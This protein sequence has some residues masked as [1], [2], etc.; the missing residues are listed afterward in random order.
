MMQKPTF[1]T[2]TS[3][4]I[5]K[6]TSTKRMMIDVLIALT[7]VAFFSIYRFGVDAIIRI[8][9]SLLIFILV[10]LIYFLLVTKVEGFNFKDRLTQ[11]FK[12]YSVNHVTAPAVSGLIFAMLLPDGLNL[13]VVVMGSI[14]GAFI[15][16]M[17]FGG[18]GYNLFNPAALGRV[19]I[20]VSFASFFV[21]S[22]G[23]VDAA[24]GA[25]PLSLSFAELFNYY[26]LT[27]L[28]TG[29]IPGSLGEVNSILILI[30]A[31]YLFIRKSAD[32]RPALSAL[33]IFVVL[34]AIA[35]YI[36]YPTMVLEYVLFHLLSGG[37]LFG[38]AFMVTDPA[39][40]P[41]TRPGRWIYGLIIGF[42][43]FAIRVWG[44]LPEGVAFAIL[45]GNL[46]VPLIDY[47]K[48]AT[49]QYRLRFLIGYGVSFVLLAVFTYL[50]LGGIII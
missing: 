21:G 31:L 7:P 22:Y 46:V 30:G 25:T 42:L 17:V 40:S 27:D 45:L 14:F 6:E 47:P 50:I 41:V 9:L 20:A 10:E 43:I 19:F 16:K 1:V 44:N 15:G 34:T 39:T 5:R 33:L 26:Q 11:K 4:Y 24:A 13:Y 48:F 2:Q 12:K 32:F 37:F 36:L 23:L 49:N 3:P 38:L 28:L 18:L 35:G 29:N 8:L